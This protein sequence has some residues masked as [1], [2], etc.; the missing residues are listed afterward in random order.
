[1]GFLYDAHRVELLEAYQLAGPDVEVAFGPT[2]AS[3]GREPIVGRFRIGRE[4]VLV[5]GNHFK[6]KWGDDPLFGTVQ[7]PVR[8]TEE[9][10][11]AQ[12][13]VVRDFVNS[14]VAVDPRARIVVTGDLNDFHFPEPGEG[15]DPVGILEGTA[16]EVP[17]VNLMNLV[18]PAKR[19][20]F[21]F[22]GNSQ[23]LDHMLVSPALLPHLRAFNTLHLNAGFPAALSEDPTTPLRASDHDALEGRFR[24]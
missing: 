3:P 6:S 14:I 1:M 18:C 4:E 13:R 2:S 24:F 22:E 11:K 7:P 16:G 17:L 5:V 19:Y 20:T 9:Q 15:L 10:R 8:P 12:A 21:I 23:V